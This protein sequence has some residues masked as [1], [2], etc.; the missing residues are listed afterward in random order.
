MIHCPWCGLAVDELSQFNNHLS[1]A[2][3]RNPD[4]L[5]DVVG[6]DSEAAAK[7]VAERLAEQFPGVDPDQLPI[8]EDDDIRRPR[9]KPGPYL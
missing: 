4:D 1:V 6:P 5:D 7:L 3:N 8:I 9:R 2:H